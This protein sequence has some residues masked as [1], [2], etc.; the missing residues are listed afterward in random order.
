MKRVLFAS[1]VLLSACSAGDMRPAP[2][3]LQ[4]PVTAV[5][6]QDGPGPSHFVAIEPFVQRGRVASNAIVGGARAE[7]EGQR[8]VR[9]EQSDRRL[10]G[11][12][13]MP[14]WVA[15]SAPIQNVFWETDEVLGSPSFFGELKP[16]GGLADGPYASFDWL[17]G[18]GLVT[19]SGL[20]VVRSDGSAPS[21]IGPAGAVMAVAASASF[22]A[23]VKRF[24]QVVV[25]SDGGKSFRELP[26]DL[27]LVD[28]ISAQNGSILLTF[29]DGRGRSLG[30]DMSLGAW[31][32]VSEAEGSAPTTQE[33]W[34]SSFAGGDAFEVAANG[35]AYLGQG[36][37][38]IAS[39]LFFGVLDLR[40]D[41]VLSLG[42]V[43][44]ESG[45]CT[46]FRASDAP[47]VL[48]ESADAAVVL[49]V[50]ATPRVERSFDLRGASP[51]DRF[52]GDDG[53]AL[54]FL[55]PCDSAAK[56]LPLDGIA[57]ASL[58]VASPQRSPVFCARAAGGVWRE[59]TVSAED[60][61][62]VQGWAAT[63]S[64][65]AV[66]LVAYPGTLLREGARVDE[67]G[68]TRVLRIARDEP[69]FAIPRYPAY[70]GTQLLNS[71][72][73]VRADGTLMTWLPSTMATGGAFVV[74]ISAEGVI[75]RIAAPSRSVA[76][77]HAGRF[78][79]V[80]A[81]DGRYFETTDFGENWLEVKRPPG[82]MLARPE[83]CSPIGCR[84][85][86]VMRVGW[87]GFGPSPT[88][89]AA[90]DAAMFVARAQRDRMSYVGTRVREPVIRLACHFDGPAKGDS[91]PGT[92]AFG[93]GPV[94]APGTGIPSRLGNYGSMLLPGGFGP[95]V[96]QSGDVWL[97][98]LTPLDVTADVHHFTL[99]LDGGLLSGV[100]NRVYEVR[101]APVLKAD[102]GIALLPMGTEDTCLS[103]LLAAGGVTRATSTCLDDPSLGVDLGASTLLVYDRDDALETSIIGRAEGQSAAFGLP[104]S[105]RKLA[106]IK[107]LAPF[108]PREIALG[109]R[110]DA[111]VLIAVDGDGRA[112][113]TPIDQ[114]SGT[115]GREEAVAPLSEARV[116]SDP[117]C[118][119]RDAG[120]STVV[121]PFDTEVGL[122]GLSG[123]AST[124]AGGLAVLRWSP[125][126]VCIDA[127]EIAI[128]DEQRDSEQGPV[129][130]P[131]SARKI[132]AR[133]DKGQKSMRG[134]LVLVGMGSE[135]TQ[136]IVCDGVVSRPE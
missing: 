8:Y 4:A 68:A 11:G 19:P 57:S 37:A 30:P 31:S 16:L 110:G 134:T 70:G 107:A 135:L 17:D 132:V 15:A 125:S 94:V 34:P 29:P 129:D 22:G 91:T 3:A 33:L 120:E 99:S 63:Q 117:A 87:D 96:P 67:R 122:S 23:V 38:L 39:G 46:A 69:P 32:I 105:P 93:A 10:D 133:V 18:V 20:F 127:A 42:A 108:R 41:R 5:A 44:L 40:S 79:L 85:G 130:G 28:K 119:S 61:P 6:W 49:H 126:R 77:V 75:R 7:M 128:R 65:H 83:Q 121:L 21:R 1:F 90:E 66:A 92:W 74:A 62:F 52:I 13:T 124:G 35:G 60:A 48:C 82:D 113:L 111:P 98:Y 54:G 100:S 109:R 26:Q 80:A 114:G 2:S 112:S 73:A 36:Q 81:E 55:G 12:A 95:T 116:G 78:A 58:V 56:T 53:G 88:P 45:R 24:G 123:V 14:P 118:R 43:P 47:L 59:H 102:G 103:K 86:A 106:E 51:L 64:G 131:G 115:L 104:P 72:Y 25:T 71:D 84:I 89:P 97:G 101:L 27:G 9:V 76:P 50:G 136:P